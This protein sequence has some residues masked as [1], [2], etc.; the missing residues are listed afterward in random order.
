MAYVGDGTAARVGVGVAFFSAG[1]MGLSYFERTAMAS[2]TIP[3]LIELL[4]M[5]FFLWL[6]FGVV[7]FVRAFGRFPLPDTDILT[8]IVYFLVGTIVG[9][10]WMMALLLVIGLRMNVANWTVVRFPVW[11][12][13]SITWAWRRIKGSPWRR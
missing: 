7:Y 5:F 1:I 13:L 2:K 4:R 10:V 12:G 8:I 6:V 11:I 9:T 3:Y